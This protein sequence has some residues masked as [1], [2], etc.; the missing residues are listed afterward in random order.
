ML[1]IIAAAPLETA[2]LRQQLQQPQT[3]YLGSY[4]I[5]SGQLQG[6][7]VAVAHS[8]IGLSSMAMQ[9][10]RLLERRTYQAV[11]LCGCG[12]S[13][14]QAGLTNGDLVL[15]EAEVFA[16]L[17]VATAADFTPLEQL[18][19]SLPIELV[20]PCQQRFSLQS[21]LLNWARKQLP[22]AVCGTFVSVNCCSGHPQLSVELEQRSGAICENMEGAAAAQV[23]AEYQLPL[24][25]IRGISNPTGTRDPQQWELRRGAEAAQR[26]VLALL[27]QW[28]QR[29]D[30]KSCRS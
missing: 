12:G 8:G 5:L 18:N 25:E 27:Q 6:Q 13:F 22:Q 11:L 26:A 15:A 4:Q 29:Q 10:T 7:S 28:P 21:S 20:P 23:C 2:L 9:L 24:L 3:S 1:L 16:D 19:I 14:A 17:G 30:D